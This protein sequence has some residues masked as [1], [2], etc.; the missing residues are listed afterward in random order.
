[1]SKAIKDFARWVVEESVF[2]GCDLSG[3]DIQTEA[4]RVGLLRKVPFDPTKHEDVWGT[5][6]RPGEDWYEFTEAMR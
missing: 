1:M 4:E 6:V 3:A 2:N 5:G